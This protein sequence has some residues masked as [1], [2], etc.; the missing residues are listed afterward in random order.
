MRAFLTRRKKLRKKNEEM[1]NCSFTIEHD[2]HES[3]F[4]TK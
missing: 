1:K 4:S 2:S 3:I